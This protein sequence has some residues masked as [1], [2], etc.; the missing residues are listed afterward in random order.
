MTGGLGF[1]VNVRG[2]FEDK[3]VWVIATR[4]RVDDRFELPRGE[5]AMAL[6]LEVLLEWKRG[7]DLG[8]TQIRVL[9]DDVGRELFPNG[10]DV[11]ARLK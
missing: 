9:L 11:P 3:G 6:A 7:R 2:A 10:L 5:A 1:T 4:I 8:A